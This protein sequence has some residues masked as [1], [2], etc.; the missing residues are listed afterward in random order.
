MA[1]P[2]YQ[3]IS[4][5]LITEITNGKFKKGQQFYSE[6]EICQNFRVSSTTAVKVLNLLQEKNY[7]VRF[8]GRGTFVAKEQHQQVVKLTDLNRNKNQ[9]EDVHVLYVAQKND[10]QILKKLH[11][12]LAQGYIEIIRLR[13]VGKRNVQYTTS[14][15]NQNYLKFKP[16]A[17]AQFYQ[18][19]YQRIM[20][21]AQLDPYKLPYRQ[22]NQAIELTDPQILQHFSKT[23]RK[24]LFIAQYRTTYLPTPQLTGLEYTVSYKDPQF[25]GIQ[26]D[27]ISNQSH[28]Y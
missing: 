4:N 14:F 21:D 25:W 3:E 11:L 20:E 8:Q 28:H 16:Q 10:P 27:A 23:A 19:V 18:S 24:L 13:L 7:V 26:I 1:Q 17:P 12:D 2:K 9:P 15:I 22:I 6:A 5:Q